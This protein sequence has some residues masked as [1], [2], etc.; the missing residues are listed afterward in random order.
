MAAQTSVNSKRSIAK[1]LSRKTALSLGLTLA[2]SMAV[3]A[4]VKAAAPIVVTGV[5]HGSAGFSTAGNTTTITAANQT[6]IDYS[7]F[8]VPTGDTVRFIQPGATATVLNRISGAAPTTIDGNMFANGIVY[9]VN[10]AGVMFGQGAVINVGQIYAAAGNLSNS[11]FLQGV[12]HFTDVTGSVLNAGNIHASAVNFVGQMVANSG[13][14]LAPQGTVVM[15]AG[16]DVLIGKMDG[17]MFVKVSDTGATPSPSTHAAVSNTGTVDASNGQVNMSAGDMFSLAI[18]NTGT[19]KAGNIT[20]HGGSNSTVLVSGKLDAANQ[21]ANGKGGTIKINGGNIG[22]GV[23]QQADGSYA[24]ATTTL[25]A[26]GTNG[27]GKILIGVKADPASTTGY[28]DASNYDYIGADALLNASATGSG[29]GGLVDTSGATLTVS[30]TATILTSGSGG[31]A[32]GQWLLD[33]VNIQITGATSGNITS[34]TANGLTEFSPNAA[35]PSPATVSAASI[36]A[37]LSAGDNVTVSATPATGPDI[38]TDKGDITL[39]AGASINP[40]IPAGSN[41]TLI[42]DSSNDIGILGTIASTGSGIMNVSLDAAG[43]IYIGGTG[44]TNGAGSVST[45]S[46]SSVG[47]NFSANSSGGSIVVDSTATWAVDTAGTLGGGSLSLNAGSNVNID[48]ISGTPAA[49]GPG[50]LLSGGGA[51]TIEAGGPPAGTS[52]FL[53]T[54][55]ISSSGVA[56]GTGGGAMAIFSTTGNIVISGTTLSA[57]GAQ[58]AS[59]GTHAVGAYGGGGAIGIITATSDGQT[60]GQIT[61]E[62]ITVNAEGNGG[63]KFQVWPGG[64]EAGYFYQPINPQ[65]IVPNGHAFGAYPSGDGFL[66]LAGANTI[67]T[68]Q[69]GPVVTGLGTGGGIGIAVGTKPLAVTWTIAGGGGGSASYVGGASTTALAGGGISLEFRPS[70]TFTGNPSSLGSSATGVA[71]G[72]AGPSE[73]DAF[74]TYFESYLQANGGGSYTTIQPTITSDGGGQ[75]YENALI[76]PGEPTPT[77]YKSAPYIVGDIIIG[78]TQG[79]TPAATATLSD[80][81]STAAGSITL[82]GTVDGVAPGQDSLITTTAAGDISYR[83]TLGQ[84]IP[85]LNWTAIAGTAL[86]TSQFIPVTATDTL[87]TGLGQIQLAAGPSVSKPNFDI[88]FGEGYF[89]GTTTGNIYLKGAVVDA[90]TNNIG[91]SEPFWPGAVTIN[92]TALSGSVAGDIDLEAYLYGPFNQTGGF[93]SPLTL[94]SPAP[95]TLNGQPNNAITVDG[96]VVP[97][98]AIYATGGYTPVTQINSA[99]GYQDTATPV[100]YSGFE[101]VASNGGNIY[102]GGPAPGTTVG[103]FTSATGLISSAGYTV[104]AGGG[105]ISILAENPSGNAG[106]IVQGQSV[107]LATG[108]S[109]EVS[110]ASIGTTGNA[111]NITFDEGAKINGFDVAIASLNLSTNPTAGY[112]SGNIVWQNVT[113]PIS[114]SSQPTNFATESFIHAYEQAD[115]ISGNY[116]GSSGNINIGSNFQILAAQATSAVTNPIVIESVASPTGDPTGGMTNA[117]ATINSATPCIVPATQPP[118]PPVVAF[119]AP[120][121]AGLTGLNGSAGYVSIGAYA[122][123]KSGGSATFQPGSVSI[124]SYSSIGN[125]SAAGATGN[126]NAGQN[127]YIGTSSNIASSGGPVSIFS[128][129]VLN[130]TYSA[131]TSASP[132]SISINGTVSTVSSGSAGN[133]SIQNVGTGTVTGSPGTTIAGTGLLQASSLTSHG[134]YVSV[135]APYGVVTIDLTNASGFAVDVD[136]KTGAG[137]VDIYGSTGV[138]LAA[139]GLSAR[140]GIN[141][142]NGG[143]GGISIA[144]AGWINVSQANINSSSAY[145][146]GGGVAIFS[147]NTTG[148]TIPSSVNSLASSASLQVNLGSGSVINTSGGGFGGGG[149]V[150]IASSSGNVTVS[151]AAITASGNGGG[152]IAINSGSG[153][154]IFASSNT[155]TSLQTGTVNTSFGGGGGYSVSLT[156]SPQ[157]LKSGGGG[158]ANGGYAGGGVALTGT[159][160]VSGGIF[161]DG[162]TV[163]PGGGSAVPSG[164]P[165]PNGA[166]GS[167]TG[168]GG[169]AGGGSAGAAGSLAFSGSEIDFGVGGSTTP[170]SL[171][172]NGNGQI[173]NANIVLYAPTTLTESGAG[174]IQLNG[175][176]TAPSISTAAGVTAG[177]TVV[178]NSGDIVFGPN[179]TFATGSNALSSLSVTDTSGQIQ[180]YSGGGNFASTTSGA[181]TFSGTTLVEEAGSTGSFVINAGGEITLTGTLTGVASGTTTAQPLNVALTSS[182][183]YASGAYA[184]DVGLNVST[185]GGNFLADASGGG[186]IQL[187]LFGTGASASSINTS[188]TNS[189]GSIT[190][191]SIAS[192]GNSGGIVMSPAG[193]SLI[194]GGAGTSTATPTGPGSVFIESSATNGTAH[195]INITGAIDTSSTTGNGGDVTIETIGQA[196]TTGGNITIGSSGSTTGTG[197]VTTAS[198]AGGSYGGG[199]VEISSGTGTVNINTVGDPGLAINT[200]GSTGGSITLTGYDGLNL[201]AGN[202]TSG[203]GTITLQNQ[204]GLL[205]LGAITLDSSAP[206]GGGNI[207][208]QTQTGGNGNIQLSGT[209]VNSGSS[210]T[211]N[212]GTITIDSLGTLVLAGADTFNS[213]GPVNGG[214]PGAIALTAAGNLT[215]TSAGSL[216]F[217]LSGDSSAVDV[218][219]NPGTPTGTVN[220]AGALSFTGSYTGTTGPDANLTINSLGALALGT[221]N[222]DFALVVNTLTGGITFNGSLGQS[223]ALDSVTAT[224]GTGSGSTTGSVT[225]NGAITAI[226]AI[227]LQPNSGTYLGGA[228]TGDYRPD[229]VLAINANLTSTNGNIDLSPAGRSV[230]PSVA[231]ITSNKSVVIS[232]PNGSITMGQNERYTGFGSVTIAAGTGTGDTVSIGDINSLSNIN[233]SGNTIDILLRQPGSI[234]TSFGSLDSGVSPATDGTEYIANGPITFTGNVITTGTGNPPRFASAADSGSVPAPYVITSYG[235]GTPFAGRPIPQNFATY[236]GIVLVL[237]ANG[238]VAQLVQIY[239]QNVAPVL[240]QNLPTVDY[241]VVPPPTVNSWDQ[242]IL[243]GVGVTTSSSSARQILAGMMGPTVYENGMYS[244]VGTSSSVPAGQYSPD[245]VQHFLNVYHKLFSFEVPANYSPYKPSDWFTRPTWYEVAGRHKDIHNTLSLAYSLYQD[246]LGASP[247]ND[248]FLQFVDHNRTQS[249]I[250]AQAANY[251]VSLQQLAAAMY[252]MGITPSQFAA[253][254]V[255]FFKPLAPDGMPFGDFMSEIAPAQLLPAGTSAE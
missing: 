205:S 237:S 111:G 23:K 253:I 135:Y 122:D 98:E 42:L 231:T 165:G 60:N 246:S 33:P 182:Q 160:S 224:A 31:G 208:I 211:D 104:E 17:N 171:T 197:Y 188:G 164:E 75:D 74:S 123:L 39:V 107:F 38:G 189:N 3:H 87:A 24:D 178:D 147:T 222:G 242:S 97:V 174:E 210:T 110:I 18:R 234:L 62:N 77:G 150:L 121:T 229:G 251:M 21:G 65:T 8:D 83:Y 202:I 137:D 10:P 203:G 116:L 114:S 49:P 47:G 238:P 247:A 9:M 69:I 79:V 152:A 2:A 249:K 105:G 187:G 128:E 16:H 192:T 186:N 115:I 51:L 22:V 241:T 1:K 43:N 53:G 239:T 162:V 6:I 56:P 138:N 226:N 156:S 215:E 14:I 204:T 90:N 227:S 133:I 63:G 198:T 173:Y 40:I 96:T 199:A 46:S 93:T 119:T 35:T 11:D 117:L 27:G 191:E 13:E 95:G 57:N 235:A 66:I 101:L 41:V 185:G 106:Y 225:V 177:L 219:F 244:S 126:P 168:V 243:N 190:I 58:G 112:T 81:G 25:T 103:L 180:L 108:N 217:A 7:K 29:A 67:R 48:G 84:N 206:T 37:A 52:I 91:T 250:F 26:T 167:G 45:F 223:A 132:G 100:T 213:S 142:G 183:A 153:K 129:A 158:G 252:Q 201:S 139:G 144:S 169:N 125:A 72:I 32:A 131:A 151:G 127:I 221:M 194:T 34:A 163:Y 19:V 220:L 175:S 159:P 85:L 248:T 245:S 218:T 86:T 240:P 161:S 214:T 89:Y 193:E 255:K 232:A 54:V 20:L 233:V 36:A 102:M 73:F 172:T 30:P 76:P 78:G 230:V 136:G 64:G 148:A 170:V 184:I 4:T 146:G 109:G 15:A 143:G 155:F 200:A 181:Q 196:G 28:S 82:D 59:G 195:N 61:L 254:E 166:G 12:N 130:S 92:T 157:V 207:L 71:A 124:G 209:S 236:N 176:G 140:G 134:G 80:T 145:G 94:I 118:N 120:N 70:Y 55:N 5:E 141:S 154:I 149:A 216:A 113:N 99:G 44:T 50:G 68:A 228:G 179:F 212:G 88:P